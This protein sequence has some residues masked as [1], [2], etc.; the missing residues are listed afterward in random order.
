MLK[1]PFTV[2]GVLAS[3]GWLNQFP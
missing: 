2:S 3:G 1:M